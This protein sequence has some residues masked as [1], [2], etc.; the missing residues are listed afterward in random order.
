MIGTTIRTITMIATPIMCQYAE[1][2]LSIDVM[3]TSNTLI[4]HT[5]SSRT[6]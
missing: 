5:A 1:T 4:R 2:V 6:A 3:R